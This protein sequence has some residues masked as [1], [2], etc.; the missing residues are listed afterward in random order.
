MTMNVNLAVVKHLQK[1]V[2][3]GE[4]AVPLLNHV[5]LILNA[6]LKANVVIVSFHTAQKLRPIA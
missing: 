1:N 5:R 6:Q 3:Q 4:I 2:A